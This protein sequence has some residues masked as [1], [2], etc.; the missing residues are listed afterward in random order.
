VLA[1]CAGILQDTERPILWLRTIEPRLAVPTKWQPCRTTFA[2][3]RAVEQARCGPSPA[4]PAVCGVPTTRSEA[5]LLL[6]RA[7]CLDEV[8]EALQRFT[9]SNP[10]A[11]SDL[12]AAYYVRAQTDDRAASDLLRA[13]EA[14]DQAVT[15]APRSAA[16]RF[17]RA[18]VREALALP[19]EW[20]EV[21]AL[22]HSEWAVEARAHSDRL[23]N[24]GTFDGAAQW[25][26]AHTALMQ[27]LQK[28]DRSQVQR[29]IA[30]FPGTAQAFL[31]DEVLPEWA[32]APTQK[33]L[34]RAALLSNALSDFTGDRMLADGISNIR[35]ATPAQRTALRIGHLALRTARSLKD[36]NDFKKA[37]VAYR[38]SVT[39]LQ[40]GGSPLAA[41]ARLGLSVT[42][43]FSK[44]E[45]WLA[46]T[47]G[48]EQYGREHGYKSIVA[49]GLATRGYLLFRSSRPVESLTAYEGARALY[50]QLDDTDD[51][52]KID[53][54]RVG[55]LCQLQQN[56]RAWH[57][58]LRTLHNASHVVEL[59]QIHDLLGET[60]DTAVALGF[61]R[62]ALVYRNLTIAAVRRQL[63]A[64]APEDLNGIHAV[65]QNL[66]IALSARAG[67]EVIAGQIDRARRDVAE[68]A[69]LCDSEKEAQT[70]AVTLHALQAHA[71][72]V[73]GR[74]LVASHSYGAAAAAF[75]R[76]VV[77]AKG[78]QYQTFFAQLL[79]ERANALR[80][81]GHVAE[82]AADLESSIGILRSEEL[83]VLEGRR[84]GERADV[85]KSYLSRSDDTYA[86]L[87]RELMEHGRT[88]EAFAYAE[89]GRGLQPLAE[90]LQSGPAPPELFRE[91]ARSIHE[92]ELRH[93]RALIAD[94]TLILE[95][96]VFDDRTCVWIVSKDRLDVAIAH[97]G[98]GTLDRWNATLQKG[99]NADNQR[100]L[101]YV[102][103]R[104]YDGLLEPVLA[105][106]G[107]LAGKRLVFV[108]D[109]GMHG[110][111]FAAMRNPATHRYLIEEAPIS[112]AGSTMLYLLSVYRD[113]QLRRENPSALLVGD[114]A[115]DTN[116]DV[117]NHLYRLG[118]A[119]D[120]VERISAWYAPACRKLTDKD[121]SATNVFA[122]APLHAVIHIA[123]HLV[124][125]AKEPL[126]SV[127]LLAK[128]P[129]DNGAVDA[130]ELLAHLKPGHTRL[131]V[132]AACSSAGGLPIGTEGVA[133]LVQPFITYG[134][135]AVVGSLWNIGDATVG[136]L[137]VSFHRHLRDGSDAAVAMQ[138]A[139]IELL[140]DTKGRSVLA[141]GAFE[142]VGYASS[143]FPPRHK[144]KEDSLEFHNSH[145]FQRTD[146]VRA[147]AERH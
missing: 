131:V 96:S 68:S 102:L 147:V 89:E 72:A 137:L 81:A 100:Y 55:M 44:P 136:D 76:A 94:D 79:L 26:R 104:A 45:D 134:V 43:E 35:R 61:P 31:L 7:Q 62:A 39:S 33:N 29:L 16:A 122:E 59:R 105:K 133:P 90:A 108:P 60:A 86:L 73:K 97:V 57:E 74:E 139:Q 127:L 22:D 38:H 41:I 145:S 98:R 84:P 112:V 118:S 106:I 99:V 17:N 67:T 140:K 56:E 138:S 117:A 109:R 120:E 103:D 30:P 128:T 69:R 93:I 20:D 25:T 77:A 36:A 123:A 146:D 113:S 130:Q 54:R 28:H 51:A 83:A 5:L 1:L 141:W 3:D 121:A 64:T 87:V 142:V 88:A 116:L 70:D 47:A 4:E 58:A 27:A 50:T 125:N 144:T 42:A 101:Q 48:V 37:A 13:L 92:S 9:P 32:A 23:R 115:F 80:L 91:A 2:P 132:L 49:A 6:S 143:P 21:L 53:A 24:R 119:R 15:R 66:A 40:Q 11:W 65:Q 110:L 12:A 111:P 107:P 8:I 124:A 10:A 19:S 95:Y 114:P 71:E 34:D 78:N 46:F 85:I 126:K 63:V 52:A 18:L 129:G 14:A 135:P 82:A 75:R